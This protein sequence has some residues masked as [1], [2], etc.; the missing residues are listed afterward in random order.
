MTE[1]TLTHLD[2]QGNPRM[3]D[4]GDKAS[5]SRRAGAEGRMRMNPT[6]LHAITANVVPKGNVAVL[7]QIAG[8]MAA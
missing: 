7:A 5:T 4:V 8:V 3:V 2:E 1:P 6:T